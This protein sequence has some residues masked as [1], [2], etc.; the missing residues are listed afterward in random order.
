VNHKLPV[1]AASRL[2]AAAPCLGRAAAR[3]FAALCVAGSSAG[4][5]LTQDIPDPALDIPTGYKAAKPTDTD[6]PP[7]LDWWRGFRSRELTDLMEQAQKVNL[8]IAAAVA[9][10]VQADALAR[11]AGA[12]LLPSLTGGGQEVYFP[13]LRLKRQWIEHRRA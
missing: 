9:R 11:Q 1:I 3:W 13:H 4:C 2:G 7:T 5:V 10:F 12:A 6:A 8:D